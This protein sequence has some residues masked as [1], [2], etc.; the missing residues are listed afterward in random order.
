MTVRAL[1]ARLLGLEDDKGRRA[2]VAIVRLVVDSG[3]LPRVLMH[4]GDPFVLYARQGGVDG[5]ALYAR[6]RAVRIDA[7]MIVEISE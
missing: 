5:S 2:K 4:D 3:P 1:H 7:G 6:E